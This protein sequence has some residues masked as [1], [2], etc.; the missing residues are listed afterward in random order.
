[1]KLC[2]LRWSDELDSI[3]EASVRDDDEI[4]FPFWKN[5]IHPLIT[6]FK[7][8]LWLSHKDYLKHLMKLVDNIK[9]DIVFETGEDVPPLN[10]EIPEAEYLSEE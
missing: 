1:M 10:S 6:K 4:W 7:C 5:G 3:E 8:L 9:D 2:H